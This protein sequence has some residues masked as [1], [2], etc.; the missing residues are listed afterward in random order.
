M[1]KKP[2]EFWKA[3]NRKFQKNITRDVK[4]KDCISDDEVAN[5]FAEKFFS[6][7]Y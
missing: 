7:F 3:W 1:R 2:A 4:I 5:K 6:V